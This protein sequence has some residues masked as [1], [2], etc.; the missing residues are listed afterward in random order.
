MKTSS[1]VIKR[2]SI[3]LKILIKNYGFRQSSLE[4]LLFK[5]GDQLRESV[6]LGYDPYAIAND[7]QARYATKEK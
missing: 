2:E 6:K 7:L 1:F 5:Y 3:V 4:N